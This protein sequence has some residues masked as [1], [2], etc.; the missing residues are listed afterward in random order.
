MEHILDTAHRIETYGKLWPILVDWQAYRPFDPTACRAILEDS[1]KKICDAYDVI[2]SYS[3][4]QFDNIPKEP[5]EL[6]WHELGRVK[7]KGGKKNVFGYYLIAS[8]SKHLMLLWGQTLAFDSNVRSN[9]PLS[10]SVPRGSRWKFEDWKRAIECFKK[11]LEQ[12]PEIVDAFKEES[13][14]RYETN[15]MVPYGRFL[16]IYYY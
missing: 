5:L 4:M 8:L 1:L 9:I 10:Y 11:D 12:Q 13:L 7:E 3:L 2:R 14:K 15:S 16:D 6:I